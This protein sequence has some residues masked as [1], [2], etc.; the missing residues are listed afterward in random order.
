[1]DPI[2][3]GNGDIPRKNLIVRVDPLVEI[4]AIE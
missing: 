3:K 1:M 2:V 4:N